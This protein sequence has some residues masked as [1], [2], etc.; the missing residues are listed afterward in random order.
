M[1]HSLD[2]HIMGALVEL[3]TPELII[4]IKYYLLCV[5]LII[6][7]TLVDDMFGSIYRNKGNYPLWS[8]IPL[9]CYISFLGLVYQG[10]PHENLDF[11]KSA[12]ITISS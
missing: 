4:L 3:F 2:I 11:I 6:V 10:L 5:S 8:Y 12:C 9:F 7:G 1:I